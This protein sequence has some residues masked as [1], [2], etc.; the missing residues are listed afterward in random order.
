MLR[1][2][3]F[4]TLVVLIAITGSLASAAGA[5]PDEMAGVPEDEG[6]SQ[7][8]LRLPEDYSARL[9]E[10]DSGIDA[11][12]IAQST[13]TDDGLDLVARGVRNVVDATTDVWAHN[14]YAYTGTFNSPCGGSPGGGVWI[15]STASN[16]AQLVGVIPSPAGSRSNDVKVASMNSGDVLVHSNEP[17]ADGPGGFEIYNVDNPNVPVH[18]A[19]VGPIDEL[20]PITDEAFGGISD[21]GVHN[22]WLFTDGAR[23][24]VAAVVESA[25]DTF[26]IYDITDPI[27]P[28][29]ASTWGAEEVL[30]PGVSDEVVDEERVLLAASWLVSGFGASRNRFLHDV[31]ISQDGDRAYLSNWDA[32]L[33]QLDV[34]S[35][36]DP[37]YVSTAL[38]PSADGDGEVNSHAAWPSEDGSI[39]V[40]TNEDFSPFTVEFSIDTGP[41]IGDFA[42]V[43]AAFTTP[44]SSIP[45]RELTGPTTYVGLAC[46]GDLVP[47]A[48]DSDRI[49]LIQRGECRFD[50]KAANVIAKGYQGMVV[51]NDAVGGE[52]LITMSGDPRSIPGVLVGH[53]T[54]LAVMGVAVDSDLV[55]GEEGAEVTAAAVADGWGQVRIWDFSDPANPVLASSFDTLCSS[56]VIDS[57]CDPN[58]TYSVH[59]VIV[60]TIGDRVKAYISWYWDGMLILDVTDPYEPVETAR[61]LDNSTNEG[62]AN[63]FWGVHKVQG[64]PFIY[65]SDRNGGLYVFEDPSAGFGAGHTGRFADDDFSIFQAD[66]EWMADQGITLGCNLAGTLFCPADAVTRA[67]TASFLVRALDLPPVTGNRFADVSGTHTA[68]INALAEAGITLGC[69]EDGSLFCPDDELTRAQMASLLARALGLAPVGANP[70]ADVSGEHLADVVA[71]AEA[72]IT[73]GCNVE[74]TLFCPQGFVTRGQTAAFLHRALG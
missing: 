69:N 13:S 32:G 53:S 23:D 48:S 35:P 71:I 42:T 7:P 20:N 29:L 12:S 63:D 3:R 59:N 40:E 31:T 58:G 1:R 43:E 9:A 30:D 18:L 72:G 41:Q 27:N 51:F 60:E 62:L 74:G 33:I 14:G 26:R 49:A 15:W 19:S 57:S 50:E 70:F 67:Q 24:Y 52:D 56:T 17:C 4:T 34:S 68:D 47:A 65:A 25:F 6:G 11:A 22:L 54:G 73:M 66:I 37:R 10:L 45:G 2:N 61:F 28:V 36:T 44:I 39:V 46:G 8:Q 38:D 5:Q 64:E 16:N 21:V 55:I